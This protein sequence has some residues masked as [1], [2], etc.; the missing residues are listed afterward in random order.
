M[1]EPKRFKHESTLFEHLPN[2]LFVEIFG[3]LNGVDTVYAFSQLNVRFQ[4]LLNHYVNN[5]NFKF[6]SKAK[7]N[8]I[9]Q[10]HDIHKWRSLY[11]SDDDTTPG[12]IKYFSRLFPLNEYTQQLESLTVLH[13]KPDYAQEFLLQIRSLNN[14]V[15]LSIG[16]ICGLNIQSIE[17]PS[18]KRLVLTSCKHTCWIKV[19]GIDFYD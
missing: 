4:C 12:Q 10:L 19:S 7:F 13:M 2:E 8:Y 14:L 6:I 15:S 1:S 16:L 18:L 5:F 9:T 3:Y 17:L 11:L